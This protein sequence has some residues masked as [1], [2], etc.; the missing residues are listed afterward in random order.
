[1]TRLGGVILTLC[2]QAVLWAGERP[3]CDKT[4][5][6][7]FWPPRTNQE[8]GERQ[9]AIRCGTLQVCAH[10]GWRYRWEPVGEPYWRLAKTTPPE[11]CLERPIEPEASLDSRE[12]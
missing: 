10:K 11:A 3:R 1:M 5:Q 6:G 2:A 7:Q 9:K 4:S 8:R 12:P